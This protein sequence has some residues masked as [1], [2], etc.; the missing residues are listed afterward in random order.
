[1]LQS[2]IIALGGDEIPVKEMLPKS[3]VHL[4]VHGGMETKMYIH[5]RVKSTSP[6]FVLFGL[7]L[8]S[9]DGLVIAEVKEF[10]VQLLTPQKDV[11][12]AMLAVQWAK[13]KDI[14]PEMLQNER[15]GHE[16]KTL[17]ICD[18]PV[19][20]STGQVTL[21]RYDHNDKAQGVSEKFKAFLA[22]QTVDAVVL[23][24]SK[25]E[26]IS[27]EA[28]IIQSRLVDICL[29]IQNVIILLSKHSLRVPI[30]MITFDACYSDQ[31]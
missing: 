4:S 28:S 6:R 20:N 29:L 13:V 18:V 16:K 26:R 24:V 22:T 8:L 2:T 25:S 3:V 19:K 21:I 31:V 12:P 30:Y 15:H 10:L 17:V 11:K 14:T 5:A 27:Q 7:K 23:Q 9:E 1:M